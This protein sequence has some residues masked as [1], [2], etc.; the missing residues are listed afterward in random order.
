MAQ[1]QASGIAGIPASVDGVIC[2]AREATIPVYDD[3]L[4]RGDGAFEYVHCYAGRPFTLA[5]HLDRLARTCATIR[6]PYPRERLEAE[7]AA[8]LAS[9]GPI[10]AGMR[11]VLTRGGRRIV[12]RNRPRTRRRFAWR[13]SRTRRVWCWPAPRASRM[14]ATC[15]PSV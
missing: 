2:D 9:A 11:I 14:P 8:L 15:W 6:L 5:E 1:L 7:I 4:L 10:F 12:S 13:S 3:G